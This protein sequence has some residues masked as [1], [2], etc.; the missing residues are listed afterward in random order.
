MFSVPRHE[1]HLSRLHLG[2]WVSLFPEVAMWSAFTLFF[3]VLGMM[4]K[5]AP[6]DDPIAR[7]GQLATAITI[8]ALQE[9]PFYRDDEARTRTAALLVSVAY[10]ES[11]LVPDAIGDGGH[12][13]CAFQIYDGDRAL[14]EDTERC[15]RVGHRM[16]LQSIRVDRSNPVA[17]YARGPRYGSDEAR[18]ISRDRV[19]L[20]KSLLARP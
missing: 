10:R 20:A 15:V 17:F 13:V 19:A 12:S 1:T 11:S 2:R 3:V 16:L 7:H 9:P 4:T 8:V 18:R 14:L 6:A 5:L